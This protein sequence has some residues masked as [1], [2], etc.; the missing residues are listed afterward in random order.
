M[1]REPLRQDGFTLL[2]WMITVTIAVV[3]TSAITGSWQALVESTTAYRIQS[4][5]TQSFADARSQAVTR[6]NI[7]TLCPLDDELNCSSDWEGPISVFIDPNN[8][9]K[10]TGN[11][12]LIQTRSPVASGS[13]TASNSG[14][15]ER[16]Y[17]QY[18]PDGSARGT[19][20]NIIWCPESRNTARAIQ[21]RMNFGGRITWAKDGNGDGIREDANG[22]VLACN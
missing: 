6:G 3:I 1:I 20:G 5:L 11:T 15:A 13:L 10:L 8:E 21:L 17:F 19:I 22:N 12:E 4:T 14:P 2:E 7:A 9:R 16:R 18:D